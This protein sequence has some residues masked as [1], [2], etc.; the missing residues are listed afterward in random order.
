MEEQYACNVNCPHYCSEFHN[1][2]FYLDLETGMYNITSYNNNINRFCPY[3]KENTI[4]SEYRV[5]YDHPTKK[6]SVE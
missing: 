1:C 2:G 6:G 5:Y 4:H 3:A